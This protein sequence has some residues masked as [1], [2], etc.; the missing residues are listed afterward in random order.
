MIVYSLDCEFNQPSGKLTQIGLVKYNLET[1]LELD[2]FE[3]FVNCGEKLNPYIIKLCHV[4]VEK[5]NKEKQELWFVYHD[6]VEFQKHR[7]GSVPILAWGQGD[8]WEIKKQLYGVRFIDRLY[9]KLM[10]RNPKWELGYRT[11]DVKALFQAWCIKNGRKPQAGLAKA[12][13]IMGLQF[14]GTKHTAGDDAYNTAV[15]FNALLKEFK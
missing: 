10:G 7:N 9:N 5:Y 14:K 1:G 4:D 12:M 2:R 3:Q 13:R 8:L 11:I 6:L 15:I